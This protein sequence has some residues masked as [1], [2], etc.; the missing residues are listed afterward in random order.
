MPI[1]PAMPWLGVKKRGRASGRDFREN[2]VARDRASLATSPLVVG[3]GA[4][5]SYASLAATGRLAGFGRH[6]VELAR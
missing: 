2:G 5:Y 6:V 1:V 4:C 3:R